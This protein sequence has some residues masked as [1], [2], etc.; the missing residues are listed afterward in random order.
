MRF[1]IRTAADLLKKS[2]PWGDYDQVKQDL[3]DAAAKLLGRAKL[4]R[5]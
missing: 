3:R 1:T 2:K 4:P 5:A